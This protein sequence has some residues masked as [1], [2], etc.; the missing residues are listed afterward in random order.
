MIKS[1]LTYGT[2]VALKTNVNK[3]VVIREKNGN[4]NKQ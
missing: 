1:C 3:K 2:R 4:V